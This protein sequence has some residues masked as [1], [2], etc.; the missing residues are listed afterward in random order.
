MPT[1]LLAADAD[2]TFNGNFAKEQDRERWRAPARTLIN[3]LDSTFRNIRTCKELQCNSFAFVALS[4]M[5]ASN[6]RP[7]KGCTYPALV[8][9]PHSHCYLSVYG[10]SNNKNNNRS[11][12]TGGENNLN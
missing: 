1:P 10:E 3:T 12:A 7:R 9:S 8:Q 4:V 6:L 5:A 11:Q 2:A